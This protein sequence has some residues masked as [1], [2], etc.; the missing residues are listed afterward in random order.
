M[1]FTKLQ[2]FI[3]NF[4]YQIREMIGSGALDNLTVLVI[5]VTFSI[6]GMKWR[7]GFLGKA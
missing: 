4:P 5:N 2:S 1:L 7:L 3:D 6:P